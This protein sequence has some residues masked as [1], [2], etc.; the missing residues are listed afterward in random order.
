MVAVTGGENSGKFRGASGNVRGQAGGGVQS[1]SLWLLLL[2]D[3]LGS[4]G[5]WICALVGIS[6]S[7]FSDLGAELS[8][9]LCL[10]DEGLEQ[11][12]LLDCQEI[13]TSIAFPFPILVSS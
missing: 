8:G 10:C 9:Q 7:L 6:L 13:S 12:S 4:T 1:W 11:M 3:F 5:K 2:L